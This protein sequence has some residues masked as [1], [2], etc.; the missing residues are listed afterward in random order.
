M[1]DLKKL[2]DAAILSN[3]Y[4]L[5]RR[6][7]DII[8][9]KGHLSIMDRYLVRKAETVVSEYEDA[10]A[11]Q[12]NMDAKKQIGLIK[13]DLMRL[14]HSNFKGKGVVIKKMIQYVKHNR[15]KFTISMASEFWELLR[16][17]I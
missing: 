2:C 15:H 9:E 17:N 12:R 16:I 7:R 4:F 13:K 10:W 3:D 5:A 8:N 11:F 1:N 14:R 6:V